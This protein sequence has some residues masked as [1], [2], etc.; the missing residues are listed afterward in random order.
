MTL[1]FIYLEYS[2]RTN[3]VTVII[4]IKKEKMIS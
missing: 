1:S 2:K 3:K 4:K